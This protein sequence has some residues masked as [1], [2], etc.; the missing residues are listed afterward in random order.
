[1]GF[2]ADKLSKEE[3]KEKWDL[4]KV[5]LT[6][7]FTKLPKYGLSFISLSG[8][9]APK[10]TP[11]PAQTQLNLGAFRL[12]AEPE[13]N[14]AVGTLFARQKAAT[15]PPSVAASLRDEGTISNSQQKKRKREVNLTPAM[16]EE[17]KKRKVG[18]KLVLPSRISLPGEE[19][20]TDEEE[21]VSIF[22][23]NDS[24]VTKQNIKEESEVSDNKGK[25]KNAMKNKVEKI[26]KKAQLSA[27]ESP[28]AAAES[29]KVS[30]TKPEKF[31]P[32]SN[33]LKGVVFTISGF[34][35]PLRGEI[36]KKGL[37]LGAKYCGDWNSSCTHLICAFTNT[38]KFNQVVGKGKIVK[39][40]WLEECYKQRKRLPWRRFCLDKKDQLKDES[41]DEVWERTGDAGIDETE[42]DT[43]DEIEMI[44]REEK[45]RKTYGGTDTETASS[46]VRADSS[47]V[48]ECDTDEE[49][50][51][52]KACERVTKEENKSSA[53]RNTN[54][55][56]CDTDDEVDEKDES[57]KKIINSESV[58]ESKPNNNLVGEETD[59][60]DAETDIDEEEIIKL[61]PDT[62]ICALEVYQN[63]STKISS[64]FME[65]LS[66]VRGCYLK[67]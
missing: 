28:A 38:P 23:K 24:N 27:D 26:D 43:D 66:L 11:A 54:P 1:M 34:Q 45:E 31:A 48:Y 64:F 44:K 57:E 21:A 15:S 33:L 41:E 2:G 63:F 40:D 13:Q 14:I 9:S 6:Q 7:P 19:S 52:I 8:P 65:T 39:K 16:V 5:V 37:D 47:C 32:F 36:R 29:T 67:D 55:Y 49:V 35:N 61:L 60:Y 50:E 22:K 18:P 58:L 51:N 25:T 20:V 42:M 3:A 17:A 46:S 30:K 4:V 10:P 56:D 53:Q 62:Q 12:K 59:P